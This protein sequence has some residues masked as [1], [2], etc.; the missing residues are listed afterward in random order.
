M[1]TTRSSSFPTT[2]RP[3]NVR[4]RNWKKNHAAELDECKGR[5][6]YV[7]WNL[8]LL[9]MEKKDPAAVFTLSVIAY[10]DDDDM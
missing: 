6:L 4:R 7:T 3:L 9:F 5:T 1:I 2:H 8:S 10:F